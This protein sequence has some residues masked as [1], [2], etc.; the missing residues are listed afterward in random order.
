MN[1]L[2]FIEMEHPVGGCELD[3]ES[4]TYP[5]HLLAECASALLLFC[6]G[7]MGAA[8]GHWVRDERLIDVTAVDWDEKTLEPFR[9]AYPDEW[10]YVQA[11]AFAWA[12]TAGRRW[13]LVSAD[14]P[15]Q[16]ADRLDETLP[17]WCERAEL[18]VTV[19]MMGDKPLPRVP[20]GWRI[21][22]TIW[23][24]TWNFS[25]YYWLVLAREPR[26]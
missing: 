13:D 18:F 14:V 25:D 15:S 12:A 10:T 21:R 8:D 11:D 9:A 4:M 17:M 26:A 7:R 23:R 20:A 19:T 3:A 5:R 16:Y 22:E 2:R 24:S 6:S 1:A